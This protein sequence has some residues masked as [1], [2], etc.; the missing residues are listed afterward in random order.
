MSNLF[1]MQKLA[2]GLVAVL[3][4]ALIVLLAAFLGWGHTVLPAHAQGGTGNG[5]SAPQAANDGPFACTIDNIAV[6]P[7][8]IHVHCT[9]SVTVGSNAVS[10]FVAP[11]DSAH[12]L[13]TNRYLVLL[14][15]AYTLGKKVYIYYF[16]DPASNPP[17][18]N[19]GD[20]RS[21]EWMYIV[22]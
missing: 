18:C 16:P 20:C 12:M 10:Y 13:S 3:L 6:F 17:G 22:P 11:G 15:T 7:D 21:I 14:N 19:T 1:R 9:T 8:R 2:W 5:S 4:V